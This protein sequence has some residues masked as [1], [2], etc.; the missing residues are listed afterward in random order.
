MPSTKIQYLSNKSLPET[1]KGPRIHGRLSSQTC[2]LRLQ[3]DLKS[4]VKI[5]SSARI[6]TASLNSLYS[7][8]SLLQFIQ[9][10]HSQLLSSM[11]L[12]SDSSSAFPGHLLSP[13]ISY[14]TMTQ[15]DRY[16]WFTG[17]IRRLGLVSS[18]DMPVTS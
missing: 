17:E 15:W 6:R 11:L 8:V 9:T 14:P 10:L 5:Q 12:E 7:D 1:V 13:F 18:S 2:G 3:S 16:F 4:E